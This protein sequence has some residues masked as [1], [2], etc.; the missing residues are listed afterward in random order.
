M[1]E[2]LSVTS[3]DEAESIKVNVVRGWRPYRPLVGLRLPE[4][5][6]SLLTEP[7]ALCHR[8]QVKPWQRKSTSRESAILV[9][10]WR[11]RMFSKRRAQRLAF[12]AFL[13]IPSLSA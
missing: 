5:V 10:F 9:R 3:E 7:H 4:F 6:N 2:F 1:N 11:S 8:K 13:V 12:L